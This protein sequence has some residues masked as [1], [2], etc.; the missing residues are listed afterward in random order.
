MKNEK[1]SKILKRFLIVLILECIFL[2]IFSVQSNASDSELKLSTSE[3]IIVK[4]EIGIVS[5][6]CNFNNC[7]YYIEDTNIAQVASEISSTLYIKGIDNGDTILH[8]KKD[9]ITV[10]CKIHVYTKPTSCK[11]EKEEYKVYLGSSTKI[12][13][14][15]TIEPID[16][17]C[18]TKFSMPF[19][20]SANISSDGYLTLTKAGDYLITVETENGQHFNKNISVLEPYFEKSN[21]YIKYKDS[22]QLKLYGKNENTKWYSSNSE[23]V[24]VDN[25]GNA[26]GLKV[27]TAT[28]TADTNGYKTSTQITVLYEEVEN[29]SGL[30]YYYDKDMYDR[31]VISDT[32]ISLYPGKTKKLKIE[33]YNNYSSPVTWKSSNNKIV[34]VSSDG[35]VTAVNPGKAYIYA[36]FLDFTRK[37]EV[38]VKSPYIS[39]KISKMAIG[40][41]YKLKLKGYTGKIKWKTSNSKVIKVTSSG[42]ITGK[43]IGTAT[44]TATANGKKIKIKIKVKKNQIT[45]KVDKD[46]TSYKYGKPVCQVSK[47]Y[48]SGKDLIAD[49]WVI[50]TRSLYASKFKYINLT[51]TDEN[52][53]VIAKKKFKNIPIK[54]HA[55]DS[56]KITFKFTGKSV[57]N[58]KAVLIN[59]VDFDYSYVYKYEYRD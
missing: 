32:N 13:I 57:K 33:N 30:D 26:T 49:V 27:G 56:K 12:K 40:Q 23:V 11:F 19:Y 42:K 1:K 9:N 43:K 8:V 22:Y 21:Y 54:L 52:N 31:M 55:F 24:K 28:V 6:N 15:Y 36:S 3:L 39:N 41:T 20:N 10:Q 59:G 51:I 35:K 4:D 18:R 47:V 17:N 44:I 2:T 46:A 48:Y 25:K 7:T 45:Y 5:L 53:K 50:N 14:N 38:V 37:C 16:C 34:K 58:K 29:D